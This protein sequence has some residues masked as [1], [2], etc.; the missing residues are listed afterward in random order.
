MARPLKDELSRR[1]KSL[2]LRL[3]PAE[4]AW[5]KVIAEDNEENMREALWKPFQAKIRRMDPDK[6]A[7]LSAKVVQEMKKKK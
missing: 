1:S 6:M 4:H 5:I 7:E 2:R 3:T